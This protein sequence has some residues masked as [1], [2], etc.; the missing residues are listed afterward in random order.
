M[1]YLSKLKEENSIDDIWVI[2]GSF[3]YKVNFYK[4]NDNFSMI[5]QT[6]LALN[7]VL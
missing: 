2:G 5:M 4:M 6:I 3:I 1:N 7:L